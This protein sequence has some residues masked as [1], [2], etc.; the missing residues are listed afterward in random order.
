MKNKDIISYFDLLIPNP[1]CPLNYD[2]DYELLIA[3]V[4]S[5]QSKDDRV[6]EVTKTLFSLYSIEE[7]ATIDTNI[8][9]DIIRPC[10]NMNKKSR[11]IKEIC[12]SLLEHYDGHVPNNREYLESLPGVGRKTANVILATLFGCAAFAVDTHIE[13]VAK[14]LGIAD[15][16]DDIRTTEEKLMKFFPNEPHLWGKR[17][18]QFLLFG[19][20]TCKSQ[21]PHCEECKLQ[22]YCNFK[23]CS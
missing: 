6:N 21:N 7:L 18:L 9:A 5:A 13:R 22:Q 12:G 11:Y 10:G 3:V 19:R 23:K 2:K 15:F 1:K 4:L 8:I 14:R 20:Y 16:S 17:H